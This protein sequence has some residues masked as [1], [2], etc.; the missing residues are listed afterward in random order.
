MANFTREAIKS[1]FL[2]LLEDRPLS[3]ITVKDIVTACGVN[4]NTFY[5]YFQDIP[6]LVEEM[7]KDVAQRIIRKYPRLDSIEQCLD[8]AI[9][10]AMA[11]RRAALHIYNSANRSAYEQY[12]WRVCEYGVERYVETLVAGRH[13]REGDREVLVRDETC[14]AF[15][16]V[17]YWLEHGMREDLRDPIHR[18]CELKKGFVEEVIRRSE[19]S[20]QAAIEQN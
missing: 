7:V 5:Y 4:R 11:H 15:G 1:A 20:W 2:Q 13:M 10:F 19:E 16:V 8:A 17:M 14:L 12:L 6:S 3:Q 9:E 18:I